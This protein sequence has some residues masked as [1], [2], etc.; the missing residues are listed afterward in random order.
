MTLMIGRK[1]PF[2]LFAV[3]GLIAGS[4]LLREDPSGAGSVEAL[5]DPGIMLASGYGYDS[6]EDVVA[7]WRTRVQE[8]PGDYLSRTQLGRSL[9][10]LA[11]ETGD[12]TLY[13]R[14][15]AQLQV[16]AEAAPNDAPALTGLAASFSAQ[17][18]FAEALEILESVRE[19][20]PDDLG[21]QAAIADAHI[22][23]GDYDT[24]FALLDDVVEQ[25][26]DTVAT[27]SRQARVAAL[28]GDNEAAVDFA[29]RT[30]IRAADFGLRPSEAAGMWFQLAFFQYQ[31]G[32][33]DEA[34]TTLGSALRIDEDHLGAR[35][36][37]GKVLVAQGSLEEAADLYE[38]I[39]TR[40]PAADLHGLLAEVYDAQGRREDAAEQVRL[41]LEVAEAQ[42][43]RFPAERRHLAGFF[44]DHDPETFLELMEEDVATREDIGGLDLLAW[45]QYLNGDGEEAQATM[46]RAMALGTE[47]ATLLF[48]AGMI[49]AEV[50]EPDQARDL[51]E[52]ALDLNPGFDLSDVALARTTLAEL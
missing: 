20:R 4:A 2:A 44:A 16:A 14:A 24:A 25:Y 22:D 3:A 23:L 15:E 5:P 40:T 30:L 29:R 8:N 41:G 37:L 45:A 19:A 50:G 9:L 51:L 52:S 43:G 36:L 33:I 21:V 1:L 12:L 42:V 26:P 46:A 49:E 27:L 28:T 34:E 13:E 32:L 7:L 6:L 11:K 39:L 31:A 47:E 10:G 38:D 18:E 17:H 35:E 48:H